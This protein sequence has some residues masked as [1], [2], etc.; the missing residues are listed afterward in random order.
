VKPSLIV[1][2]VTFSVQRAWLVI[3]IALVLAGAAGWFAAGHFNMTTDTEQLISASLPWRQNG[4][5]FDKA[6]PEGSDTIVAVVDGKTPELAENAASVLADK[7]SQNKSLILGVDRPDGG[8]FWG[9]EGLLLLSPK[10][11]TDTTAQLIKAQPFLGPLA[12]DPS[13]RGVMTSLQTLLMGVKT[14]DAKLADIDKP[15]KA[16]NGAM[17]DAAD[18]KTS[19]FSWQALLSDSLGSQTRKFVIVRPKLDYSALEPG[20]DAAD[21]IRK[22]VRDA[23]LDAA[24]G[25]TVRLTGSV[26]LSDEEFASLADRAGLMVT[27]MLSAVLLM[28]WL[29]VRSVRVTA[30]IMVCTIIGLV[31]TAGLGLAVVGRFNL[32]S[33]AFIPLFVGLG[34]DFGIQ[35]AVRYRAESRVLATQAEALVA[36]GRDIGGSLAL[37]AAAI[38]AGFFAFLPTHYVGVSELGVIAGIGMVVAFV[39]AIS[40]LP[41]L[42][43]VVRPDVRQAKGGIEALAPLDHLM[44]H[45]RKLVLMING[46]LALVCVCLLPFLHFDSNPL[47]LKNPHS[48]SMS[49]LNSL[50]KDPDQ[51]PNT[52]DVLTP[53]LASADALSERLDKLPQVAHAVT[54][55][56]F[57]PDD[58]DAKMAVI[59]DADQLLDLT[60]NPLDTLPAPSDADVV[61]ALRQTASALRDAAATDA[62][63]A[64]ADAVS[65]ATSLERLASSD[66]QHRQL[67]QTALV[68]PLNTLFSQLRLMLQA[69][70]LARDTLSP[71]IVSQWVAPTGQAR[72]EV[73]PTGGLLDDAGLRRFAAAVRAVAPNSSGGPVS[74]V[75]AGRTIVQ[76]FVEAGALS[77]VVI[78]ILLFAVLRRLEDVIYTVLPVML[79]GLLTLGTCVIIGQPLNFA[80]IIALPLLFGIGVAF[81]IYLVMAWRAGEEHFLT[82]SLTRAVLFSGLTTGMAFGALWISAHPGTASMGKLL[83]ISLTFTLATA[84]FFGPAL[85][86]PPPA[87]RAAPP[88]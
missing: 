9:R 7:L 43:H 44:T 53:S 86:G 29:A 58:Q 78:T 50:M 2:L 8:P 77:L 88:V 16:L 64:K 80:N 72:I 18:G 67:A 38:A 63:L 42:L 36:A 74:I 1:R 20:D 52:I 28:L 83:M 40:L 13:L 62:T 24:H 75:E 85:M 84:L 23:G 54:L 68:T 70:P 37:A 59:T 30:A 65:L 31:I 39:L 11:V 5:K 60:L 10:E 66:A 25:V 34:V 35:F 55:T 73:F 41:A 45:R 47:D 17:T 82:S 71:D 56:S 48:E 49:T 19:F 27:V 79:T 87:D 81:H 26:Q 21:A 69:Q 12:A 33:V 3:A 15:M 61:T 51:S 6:F 14:G 32:I 22:T 4:L 76:A 46:G 57:I